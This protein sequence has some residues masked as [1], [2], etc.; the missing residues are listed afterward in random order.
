MKKI[1]DKLIYCA[2]FLLP[3]AFLAIS[4][5][6]YAQTENLIQNP[7]VETTGFFNRRQPLYWYQNKTGAGRAV[8]SYPVSGYQSRR[9]LRVELIRST[10]PT[11][12]GWYFKDVAVNGGQKYNF[13]DFYWSDTESFLVARIRLGNGSYQY[14]DLKRSFSF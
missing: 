1:I 2:F 11:E 13:S 9:A 12:T 7:S 8:F 14:L 3:V 6:I 5:G 10:S 4:A